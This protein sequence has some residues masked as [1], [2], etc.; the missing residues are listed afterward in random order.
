[1][2]RQQRTD[3]RLSEIRPRWSI[4]AKIEPEAGPERSRT[5]E[6]NLDEIKEPLERER[7]NPRG[8]LGILERLSST[9]RVG[10]EIEDCLV[11][12]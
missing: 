11:R 6:G 4:E 2:A 3:R 12:G 10:I 8:V 9:E 1:M 5:R 7:S